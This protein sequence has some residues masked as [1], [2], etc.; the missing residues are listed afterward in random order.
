MGLRAPEPWISSRA[1]ITAPPAATVEAT[2]K[3]ED[4]TGTSGGLFAHTNTPSYAVSRH[5]YYRRAT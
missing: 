1:A 4:V 2:K 5:Y 3:L